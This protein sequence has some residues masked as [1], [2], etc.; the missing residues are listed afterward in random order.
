MVALLWLTTALVG[1]PAV[2]KEVP[3]LRSEA[4]ATFIRSSREPVTQ[5]QVEELERL[6]SVDVHS[7][8]AVL[9][10][11]VLVSYRGWMHDVY[12]VDETGHL[13][14]RSG[15][16]PEGWARLVTAPNPRVQRL[17]PPL[18]FGAR[19]SPATR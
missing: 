15:A 14:W 3:A 2:M 7:A 8:F 11:V 6:V 13:V 16:R 5:A 18:R 17:A 10:F 4:I 12:S 9:P 19:R 1:V